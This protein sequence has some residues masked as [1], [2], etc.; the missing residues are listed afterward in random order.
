MRVEE[1]L[2]QARNLS[3][4][5][6][7]AMR[8]EVDELSRERDGLTSR[9]TNLETGFKAIADD[10]AKIKTEIIDL[11]QNKKITLEKLKALEVRMGLMALRQSSY[12]AKQEELSE[13]QKKSLTQMKEIEISLDKKM[14]ELIEQQIAKLGADNTEIIES[15]T[16][17]RDTMEIN[18]DIVSLE[19]RDTHQRLQTG[20]LTSNAISWSRVRQDKIDANKAATDGAIKSLHEKVRRQAHPLSPTPI[21]LISLTHSLSTD[22]GA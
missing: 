17:I 10:L 3:R 6:L 2:E 1:K 11:R 5:E 9:V 16:I 4:E 7:A 22:G 8:E 18:K 13:N 20:T 21:I 12:K 19:V 15:I 14:K